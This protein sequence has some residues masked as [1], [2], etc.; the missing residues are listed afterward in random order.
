MRNTT[1]TLPALH[2]HR[3]PFAMKKIQGFP[4]EHV[5]R[6][7]Y[8]AQLGARFAEFQNDP[9]GTLEK[10][11]QHDAIAIMR[12]GYR[13][14]L[15]VQVHLRRTLVAQWRAEGTWDDSMAA[16]PVAPAPTSRFQ[17]I[18][19]ALGNRLA[20][21]KR[22][23]PKRDRPLMANPAPTRATMPSTKRHD[24]SHGMP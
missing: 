4:L 2:F 10:Y 23:L 9:Q 7:A 24:M 6:E 19:L 18:R 11:G 21:L 13:P 12:L 16:N 3:N 17:H 5:F 20:T 8:L 1:E 15:P 22:Y 14:L